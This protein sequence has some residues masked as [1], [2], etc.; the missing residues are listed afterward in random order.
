MADSW[1]PVPVGVLIFDRD[2]RIEALDPF[3]TRVGKDA[4]TE[5]CSMLLVGNSQA[6]LGLETIFPGFWYNNRFH[7]LSSFN[8]IPEDSTI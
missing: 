7:K 2:A 3:V 5:L 1:L 4:D 8:A 6:Y